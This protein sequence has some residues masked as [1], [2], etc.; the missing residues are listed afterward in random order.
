MDGIIILSQFNQLIDA[1]LDRTAPCFAPANCRCGPV[2]MTCVIA[3]GRA[4]AGGAVDRDRLAGA[5]AA[6]DRRGR[7]NDAGAHRHPHHAAGADRV[8][9]PAGGESGAHSRGRR[10][11]RERYPSNACRPRLSAGYRK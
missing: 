1:G 6:R 3:G 4:A 2:L 10:A 9:F 8:I 11:S 7:R 5:E